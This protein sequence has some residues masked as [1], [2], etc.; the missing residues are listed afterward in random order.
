MHNL[1]LSAATVMW[2]L[3]MCLMLVSCG[4]KPVRISLAERKA[5]DSIVSSSHNIDTISMIQK[6]MER[7]GNML[8]SIIAYREMGKLM[9]NE[10]RFDDALRMHSEGLKQAETLGDTLEIVQALNNIGTDYRR[11]GVLD[12]AQDYH[13]RAF[14][15]CKE[16]TDSSY[17][18]KKNRVVSLNGLGN[19]YLTFGNYARADSAL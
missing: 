18:A 1:R 9:R 12:M 10:S 19:I 14:N 13:Y 11:M 4:E 3:I 8:G 7:E 5:L 6:R 15:I 17:T 16:S 2:Y